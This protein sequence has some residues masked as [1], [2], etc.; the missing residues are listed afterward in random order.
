M[1]DSFF[2]YPEIYAG[3]YALYARPIDDNQRLFWNR[4]F[5]FIQVIGKRWFSPSLLSLVG[6][7]PVQSLPRQKLGFMSVELMLYSARERLTSFFI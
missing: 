6:I 1:W 3:S 4:S 7:R 2:G 5:L